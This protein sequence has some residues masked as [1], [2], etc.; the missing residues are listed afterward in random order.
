MYTRIRAQSVCL[1]MVD[2]QEKLLSVIAQK[3]AV[4]KNSIRLLSAAR[5]L[6]VPLIVTEQYPSGI[7]PTVPE[8]AEL[9]P[10]G[11]EPL[12]KM[13]FSCRG[14]S[15]FDEAVG[16]TGRE[17]MVIFGLETHICVLTTAMDLLARGMKVVVAADA[18]GSRTPESHEL[19]LSAARS[20]GA[21]VVPAET[22]VYQM[23]GVA[24]TPEF[25]ALLPLFK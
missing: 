1:L 11:T 9:L 14:A 7:G 6:S 25:K 15:G 5:E 8:L 16:E 19:A 2:I 4:L 21:L 22:V 12:S 23:L 3:E 13:A 10:E 17:M 24:G 18:C 20:C